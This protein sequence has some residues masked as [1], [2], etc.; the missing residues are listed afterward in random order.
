MDSRTSF[1]ITQKTLNSYSCFAPQ[2]N[3]IKQFSECTDSRTGVLDTKHCETR[4][5]RVAVLK[6]SDSILSCKAIDD[7]EI[8]L[9]LPISKL[10]NVWMNDRYLCDKTIMSLIK[11]YNKIWHELYST[12]IYLWWK[13]WVAV[14]IMGWNWWKIK[15]HLLCV[16]VLDSTSTL[17][18]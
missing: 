8:L 15:Q 1:S 11:D 9:N 18:I 2:H 17:C 4:R 16:Y 5:L 14:I 6:H 13:S 10:R 3:P 12:D 7:D